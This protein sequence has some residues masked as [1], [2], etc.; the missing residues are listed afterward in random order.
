MYNLLGY[1]EAPWRR[2]FGMKKFQVQM[3]IFT[4]FYFGPNDQNGLINCE[5]GL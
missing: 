3:T 1:H 5:N 2:F 4:Y